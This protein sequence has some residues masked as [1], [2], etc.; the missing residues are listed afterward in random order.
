MNLPYEKKSNC[1]KE[2]IRRGLHDERE[3]MMERCYTLD[4]SHKLLI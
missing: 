4:P 2:R 1:K 3:S